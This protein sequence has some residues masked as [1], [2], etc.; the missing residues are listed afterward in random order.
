MNI[1]QFWKSPILRYANCNITHEL[2]RYWPHL[3]YIYVSVGLSPS[4]NHSCPHTWHGKIAGLYIISIQFHMLFGD[5]TLPCYMFWLLEGKA[6]DS[7]PIQPI[8]ETEAKKTIT[9]R[10]TIFPIFHRLIPTWRQILTWNTSHEEWVHSDG[11]MPWQV[12]K[13]LQPRCSIQDRSVLDYSMA[14][15]HQCGGIPRL[16]IIVSNWSP[17]FYSHSASK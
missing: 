6:V 13:W 12:P 2:S 5:F 16:P 9:I 17:T 11:Q 7:I 15:L 14:I 8:I 10:R 3:L 4:K 1:N